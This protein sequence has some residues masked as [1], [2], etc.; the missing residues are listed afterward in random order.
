MFVEPLLGLCWEFLIRRWLLGPRWLGFDL[1]FYPGIVFWSALHF[2]W[3]ARAEVPFSLFQKSWVEDES[4]LRIVYEK[5]NVRRGCQQPFL[6]LMWDMKTACLSF[7]ILYSFF[8]LFI[9]WVLSFLSRKT[10]PVELM[11]WQG[12]SSQNKSNSFF[13]YVSTA[14]Y[15]APF[16]CFDTTVLNRKQLLPPVAPTSYPLPRLHFILGGFA[17]PS[18]YRAVLW[19]L[20]CLH[21][22][23]VLCP[24]E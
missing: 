4:T 2:K 22:C 20:I 17:L 15:K 7:S 24:K 8:F 19:S 18:A 9:L 10:V 13:L 21:L 14:F 3:A 23:C 16:T 5:K 12:F 6:G 11:F 1:Q